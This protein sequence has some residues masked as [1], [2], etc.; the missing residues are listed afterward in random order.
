MNHILYRNTDWHTQDK[1]GICVWYFTAYKST[2]VFIINEFWIC[3]FLINLNTD[4]KRHSMT[5]N[6]TYVYY[7]QSNKD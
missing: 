4:T 7:W 5:V 6:E 1:T 2:H 3:A